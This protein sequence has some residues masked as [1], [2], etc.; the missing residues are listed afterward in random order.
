MLILSE[1]LHILLC[2]FPTESDQV[3]IVQEIGNIHFACDR[4]RKN[5]VDK[6]FV[7]FVGT[8]GNTIKGFDYLGRKTFRF[9]FIM[10]PVLGRPQSPTFVDW[11]QR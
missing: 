3:H 8:V 2:D 7:S 11:C 4:V 1:P 10:G 5:S 9:E 6:R